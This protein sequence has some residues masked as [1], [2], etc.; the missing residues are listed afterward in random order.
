VGHIGPVTSWVAAQKEK[1][2]ART[3]ILVS[4]TVG[5]KHAV[6]ACPK[7]SSSTNQAA[8]EKHKIKEKP[9]VDW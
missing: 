5:S 8:H 9:P 2:L 4:A 7:M 1:G 3:N 6:Q